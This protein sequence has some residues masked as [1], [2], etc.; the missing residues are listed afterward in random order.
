MNPGFEAPAIIAAGAVTALGSTLRHTALF[1]RAGQDHIVLSP[2]IDALGEHVAM[3]VTSCLPANL[4]GAARLSALAARACRDAM[5]CVAEGAVTAPRL[6]LVLP[7]RYADRTR[8]VLAIE[9]AVRAV[10]PRPLSAAPSC[11]IFGNGAIGAR[12]L[13]EAAQLLA[14]RD[15]DAVLLCAVDSYYEW[16]T[17][18]ALIREDRLLTAD[19]LDGRRPGEA[20]AALLLT[21]R[22]HPWSQQFGCRVRAV[23]VGSEPV[24]LGSEDT[25]HAGGITAA[26]E[27]VSD[28]A[29]LR[30]RTVGR[31]W[32]DTTHEA[33][34]IR[35]LQV[36]LARLGRLMSDTFELVLPARD[37]GEVGAAT[38]ILYAALIAE[39]SRRQFGWGPLNLAFAGSE[40]TSRGAILMQQMEDAKRWR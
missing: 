4:I 39:A 26:L 13:G 9:E 34:R 1:L 10:L 18:Q 37:L 11:P 25:S 20:A 29:Q 33:Y 7:Q 32:A 21:H 14:R 5:A 12:A 24:P 28:N 8:E 22:H 15:T 40:E 3:N 31:F 30:E 35:E 16:E 36:V 17:L 23:A 27:T 38:L 6:C 19:N 2:F